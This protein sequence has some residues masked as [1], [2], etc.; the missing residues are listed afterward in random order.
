MK[1]K[2]RT[3]PK[4]NYIR[5]FIKIIK[6]S[7]FAILIVFICLGLIFCVITLNNIINVA[8]KI[9]EDNSTIQISSSEYA[10]LFNKIDNLKTSALNNQQTPSN[11]NNPFSE[12]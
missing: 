2:K 10:N 3:R 5:N 7:N 8:Y 11:Y 1:T 12:Q 9:N 4:K 6:K